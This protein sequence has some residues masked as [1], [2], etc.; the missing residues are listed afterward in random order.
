MD[1]FSTVE[2][3]YNG[4]ESEDIYV[5]CRSRAKNSIHLATLHQPGMLLKPTLSLLYHQYGVKLRLDNHVDITALGNKPVGE[6]MWPKYADC[7][8]IKKL[9]LSNHLSSVHFK[10]E[11]GNNGHARRT[12]CFCLSFQFAPSIR[13]TLTQDARS[14]FL[15]IGLLLY[16]Y[17][18][19]N[20]KIANLR[21]IPE[22]V[23]RH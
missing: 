12:I 21:F 9:F 7:S 16:I 10:P 20:N 23:S 8:S 2:R 5:S 13:E 15:R 6:S 14:T 4:G 18:R 22:M 19:P 11:T 3:D 17:T 1:H